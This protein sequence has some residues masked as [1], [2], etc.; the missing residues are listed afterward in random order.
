MEA[1]PTPESPTPEERRYAWGRYRRLMRWMALVSLATAGAALAWLW[2]IVGP[3]PAHMVVATVAG[4]GCSVLLGTA[5]MG[6]VFL[7]AGIG[8]D[9]AVGRVDDAP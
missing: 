6:L 8:Q 7:S 4:V 2:W 1:V 9:D 5:L 3:L